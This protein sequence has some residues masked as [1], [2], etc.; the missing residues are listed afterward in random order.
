MVLVPINYPLENYLMWP[1]VVDEYHPWTN[2]GWHTLIQSAPKYMSAWIHD[3]EWQLRINPTCRNNYGAWTSHLGK[4]IYECDAAGQIMSEIWLDQWAF[5][6]ESLH[7]FL[8]D[9]CKVWWD[10]K[11]EGDTMPCMM[12][13]TSQHNDMWAPLSSVSRSTHATDIKGT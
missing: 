12:K 11:L 4:S 10:Y 7:K 9:K 13:Q 6:Q 5:Q 3:F 2:S 1:A 8:K